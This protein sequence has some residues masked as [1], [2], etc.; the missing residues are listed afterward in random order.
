MNHQLLLSD[1]PLLVYMWTHIYTNYSNPIPPRS[2]DLSRAREPRLPHFF[3]PVTL[4]TLACFPFDTSVAG[5]STLDTYLRH[6]LPTRAILSIGTI[7]RIPLSLV[8]P[9]VLHADAERR[10]T[11]YFPLSLLPYRTF[12]TFKRS[13]PF[14]YSIMS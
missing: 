2:V 12:Q 13:F 7:I 14:S 6:Q 1:V 3:R 8:R 10:R 4:F 5:L 11:P 9:N